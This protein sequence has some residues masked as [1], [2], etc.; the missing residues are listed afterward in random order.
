MVRQV[1]ITLQKACFEALKK[2][3]EVDREYFYRQL[4]GHFPGM[5]ARYIRT[6]GNQHE[7]PSPREAELIELFQ[8]K[9]R[10]HGIVYDNRKIFEY[11]YT[12]E[13]KEAGKQM[14]LW[15]MEKR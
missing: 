2:L 7:L 1:C 3:R 10:Q 4:D 15:D 6:Y 13:G 11:M 14:S 5:K 12:F 9:C 8:A